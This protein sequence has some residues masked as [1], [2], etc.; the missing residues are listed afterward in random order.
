[1]DFYQELY[2][3]LSASN[4]SYSLVSMCVSLAILIIAIVSFWNI[5]KKAGQPGWKAVIPFY[6]TYIVFKISWKAAWFA[7]EMIFALAGTALLSYSAISLFEDPAGGASLF[8]VS[9][10]LLF[11]G[12][13]IGVVLN[14][15]L[16]R[17]FGHGAGYG[18]GL[19]F[20]YPI[21]LLI[22]AFG[23]S[24]YGK[25]ENKDK[26]GSDDNGQIKEK[27][28]PNSFKDFLY[29]KNDIIVVLVIIAVAGFVIYTRIGAIMDYPRIL[30][31]QA[32]ATE[33]EETTEETS[34]SDE[35]FTEDSGS[36]ASAAGTVSLTIT[37]S[38][39]SATVSE[40][41][42]EAGLISSAD[43]FRSYI[44]T[45]NKQNSLQSGTFQI[46]SGSSDEEILNIIAN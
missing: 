12:I 20:F 3:D 13:I 17:A 8:L 41:L 23:K 5:F 43:E 15:K 22:L 26:D 31:E 33:T 14:F 11:I 38:D 27:R 9:L 46:P 6:N 2:Q 36:N 1:M 21:F 42:Q 45:M 16:S 44:S 19:T 25:P 4:S 10:L 34:A 7:L 30:A 40:K 37:D 29:D 28:R 35:S 18:L 24:E 32:A 39:T